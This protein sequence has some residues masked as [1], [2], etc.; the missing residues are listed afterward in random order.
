MDSSG[1]LLCFYYGNNSI[2]L[3]KVHCLYGSNSSSFFYFLNIFGILKYFFQQFIFLSRNHYF[4]FEI[5]KKS[6][7]KSQLIKLK[8][9]LTHQTQS[10]SKV[11]LTPTKSSNEE[12]NNG[13]I[14]FIGRISKTSNRSQLTFKSL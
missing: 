11:S 7:I 14:I 2:L 4:Q 13:S 8:N 10:C 12:K 6:F 9:S 1:Y 3:K 5:V